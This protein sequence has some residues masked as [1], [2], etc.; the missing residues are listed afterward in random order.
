MDKVL[1]YLKQEIRDNK[2]IILA[3]SAGP[4][5]MCL[6]DLLNKIK[7]D[8]NLRIIIAHVNHKVREESDKE[9]IFLKEYCEKLN[10]E[11]VSKHLDE[12]KEKEFNENEAREKRYQFLDEVMKKYHGYYLLTA[13][14]G[15]DLIETILMRLTR[16]SNLKGYIGIKE[17]QVKVNYT[18]LR[19]L[20]RVNKENIL[21]YNK[22]NNIPYV[23]DKSNEDIKYTRNRYRKNILPFLKEENSNIHLKYYQFS[24]ELEEYDRFL[25]NYI[26]NK[27]L[28]IEDYIDLNK[29]KE[30][31]K[32][33]K[34]K[35]I[36]LLIREIQN[37]D[38]LDISNKQIEEIM[39]IMDK[40]GNKVINL[41]NKYI[42]LKEYN[43]LRIIK[44]KER[45]EFNYILDKDIDINNYKIRFLDNNENI[46]NSN[47]IL[48]LNKEDI[49]LPLIIRSKKDG[50][51]MT[52]KNLNGHKKINDILIDEKVPLKERDNILVITDSKNNIL[53]IPRLK[54]SQFAKDKK[55]KYDIILKCEV[56]KNEC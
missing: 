51:K 4:D 3:C 31:S 20:L 26:L 23:I 48:L 55:E 22:N 7:K 37:S 49:S 40:D 42:A 12:Y 35:C 13:H 27:D 29:I 2:T 5:S 34:R 21:E 43:K 6:L 32:F 46:D 19:P 15:D 30:E 10:L 28:L 41:N 39:N 53:W 16:G 45:K 33:I 38:Y 36:E 8:K 18:I 47:N 25:N 24:K 17:K 1:N 54:K 50:D 44:E 52:I 11:F 14:H 9:E 56:K